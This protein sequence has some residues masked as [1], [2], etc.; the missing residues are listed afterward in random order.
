V[1]VALVVVAPARADAPAASDPPSVGG[2]ATRG[3]AAT[4]WIAAL[5]VLVAAR[6]HLRLP[7]PGRL[8][9][10]GPQGVSGTHPFGTDAVG[11]DVL[12]RVLSTAG[13]SLLL[14]VAAIVVA[15]VAGVVIGVA[16]G[17][18]GGR[19]ERA[20]VALLSGW[21]TFPGELVALVLLAFNGRSGSRS[22]VALAFVAAPA[23]ARGAQQR[24]LDSIRA[25]DP[26]L[27][28]GAWLRSFGS[29]ISFGVARATFATVFVG[30]GQ[31]LATEVVAGLLGF[32]PTAART[33]S[34]EISIQLPFAAHAPQAVAAPLLVALVTAAA[35]AT[36]GKSLR[37]A[38]R[39][40]QRFPQPRVS[41]AS[42]APSA[43]G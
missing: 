7:A 16:I 35:L 28:T 17:F 26:A 1:V 21:A 6:L 15:V 8:A 5:V 23:F 33:W 39:G 14:V 11:R 38:E 24:T 19:L 30:A 10:G 31:V 34:R 36:L 18:A 4:I 32:G 43:A 9:G 37:P 22:A 40:R 41:G 25:S 29:R 27:S 3:V 13:G 42:S 12:A 2:R 20:G